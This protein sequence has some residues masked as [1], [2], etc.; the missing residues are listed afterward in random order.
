M[1]ESTDSAPRFP[2]KQM[3]IDLLILSVLA[4]G[5]VQTAAMLS[6]R[7]GE[8]RFRVQDWL[9]KFRKRGLCDLV[10]TKPGR[11]PGHPAY[12]GNVPLIESYLDT[13][14][15]RAEIPSKLDLSCL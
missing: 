8:D 14:E 10:K 2:V 3:T 6:Y 15:D 4:E 13:R 5:T 11:T 12:L 1:R 7:W 9:D